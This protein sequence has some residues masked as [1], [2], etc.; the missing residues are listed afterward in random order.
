M[1]K[2]SFRTAIFI[3]A[4]PKNRRAMKVSKLC[5]WLKLKTLE[6][7]YL[8]FSIVMIPV[9]EDT[10]SRNDVRFDR[11]GIRFGLDQTKNHNKMSKFWSNSISHP[12]LDFYED[13][14]M[15][16]PA[17]QHCH[18]HGETVKGRNRARKWCEIRSM[19][20]HWLR[21]AGDWSLRL[22][23]RFS[24]YRQVYHG[25]RASPKKTPK[26]SRR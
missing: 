21:F 7:Q 6:C 5:W 12:A 10:E 2:C 26:F 19:A 11:C 15:S 18:D 25:F 24:G 14:R 3:E 13:F 8:L 23:Q 16:G 1:W 9:K 20:W 17:V 4:N 22:W